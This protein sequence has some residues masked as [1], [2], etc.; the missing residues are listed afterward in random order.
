MNTIIV[1]ELFRGAEKNAARTTPT[2]A[3]GLSI[4]LVLLFF[5][6]LYSSGCIGLTS[7]SKSPSGQ[8]SAPAAGAISVAPTSLNFGSVPVGG[9]ASQSV[10]ITNK[11]GSKLTVM[12]VSTTAAGVTISGTSNPLTIAAG[13]QATFNV[14]FSPKAAGGLSS[15]ISVTTNLSNL[16]NTVSL[17]GLGTAAS[18]LLTASTSTLSF[19]NVAIGNS[20]ASSVTLTNAG[21]SNVTLSNV[22]LSGA[23]FSASGVSAGLILAPGQ[24]AT[25]DATFAP[26]AAGSSTGS[27]ALASNATNSPLTISLSGNGTQT[28]SHSVSLTWS[29]STSTVAGYNVHRSVVS[30]G[31]YSRL[32]SSI[33]TTDSYTDS[34]VQSGQT[35]YFVVTSVTALGA[36]SPDSTQVSVTVPTS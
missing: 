1:S 31:P 28:V 26:L 9:T 3:S 35:Y 30:G 21:N 10:T 23:S 17:S 19:G 14:V 34:T 16:P 33:V 27:V 20:G 24:S 13:K 29:P 5:A 8:Q 15:D 2:S 36:E 18:A 4:S 6:T 12:K 32:D 7:A 22:S 25:L 11:G